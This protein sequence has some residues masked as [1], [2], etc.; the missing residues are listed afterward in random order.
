MPDRPARGVNNRPMRAKPAIVA[1]AL[2]AAGCVAALSSPGYANRTALQ[3]L[4][5]LQQGRWELRPYRGSG[6]ERLCLIDRRR[7]VQL[8]H[9]DR[10]CE[11]V[12]LED[13]PDAITVQY[14]CRGHGYGRTRIRRESGQ[15]IQFETQGIVDGQPYELAAE[16]RR[17]SDCAT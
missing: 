12:I 5:Q 8:R 3:M 11:Q 10:A 17:V 6:A 16:G 13:T 14:T 2:G 4:E 7:L 15:L 1:A 9:P